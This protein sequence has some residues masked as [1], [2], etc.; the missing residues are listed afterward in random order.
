MRVRPC[1]FVC[2]CMLLIFGMMEAHSS[3]TI[4]VHYKFVPLRQSVILRWSSIERVAASSH[5]DLPS[6][7]IERNTCIINTCS[8]S[9]CALG[10]LLVDHSA[11]FRQPL[12][13]HCFTPSPHSTISQIIYNL[14]SFC[15]GRTKAKLFARHIYVSGIPGFRMCS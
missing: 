2:A 10:R 12:D 14:I 6:T 1:V 13:D 9:E 8:K 15:R 7:G 5:R 3:S 11:T 4:Q